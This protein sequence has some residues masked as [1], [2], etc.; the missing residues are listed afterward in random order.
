[1]KTKP[2]AIFIA[3]ALSGC[4]VFGP[5]M[6]DIQDKGEDVIAEAKAK[7]TVR[8]YDNIYYLNEY[9]VPQLSVKDR[10]KPAWYF[11]DGAYSFNGATM[12][13]VMREALVSKNINVRFDEADLKNVPVTVSND[14]TIGNLLEQIAFTTKLSFDFVGDQLAWSKFKTAE[15]KI[16][17]H[18]GD[19]TYSLGEENN[20]TNRLSSSTETSQTVE[21][22]F[23]QSTEKAQVKMENL[24]IW[25][26]LEESLKLLSSKE[27]GAHVR[28]NQSTSTVLVK[29]LPDNVQAMANHIDEINDTLNTSV[30]IEIEIVEYSHSK[31]YS[32][33][34][35][36]DIIKQDLSGQGV[37]N[38]GTEFGSVFDN[39]IPA[40]LGYTKESGKYA[41]SSALL[42]ALNKYGVT[43]RQIKRSLRGKVNRIAVQRKGKDTAFA[44]SS[45][46]TSTPNVGSESQLRGAV[47]KLGE[48]LYMIP[49]VVD[50]KVSVVLSTNMA[51]L[52]GPLRVFSDSSRKIE[53]PQ[54]VSDRLMLEITARDGETHIISTRTEDTSEYTE[55]STGGS[56][57]LGGER[58]TDGQKVETL[59]LITPRIIRG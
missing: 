31:G 8:P 6:S 16:A 59:I 11:E 51:D 9:Y 30:L 26:D 55:N 35:N 18:P 37:I 34:V 15:F 29:D 47:L 5:T 1:M 25:K 44:A 19:T 41:G 52:N 28:V 53:L 50:D 7:Q 45:G 27:E 58:G 56:V 33:S 17:T 38:F 39:T 23:S 4:S 24:S 3:A 21:S 14:G 48:T 46:A 49:S 57:A 36:W 42:S 20:T 13:Q 54:T 22:E 40:V 12:E 43:T 32:Q 2:L 10:T